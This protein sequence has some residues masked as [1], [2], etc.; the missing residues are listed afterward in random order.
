M[1]IGTRIF[2][3]LAVL[4]F[5]MSMKALARK[6][7]DAIKYGLENRSKVEG[8]LGLLKGLFRR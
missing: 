8:G 6:A 7:P 2:L 4:G 5:F 1:D 3:G